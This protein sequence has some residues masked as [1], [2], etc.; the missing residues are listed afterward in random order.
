MSL[1]ESGFEAN[2]QGGSLTFTWPISL[3]PGERVVLVTNQAAFEA[4]YGTGVLIAGQYDGNLNNN[5]GCNSACQ[6]ETWVPQ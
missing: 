6:E 1:S 2:H 5:D 4:R 3:A